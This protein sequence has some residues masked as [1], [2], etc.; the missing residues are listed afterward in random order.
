[1]ACPNP[2]EARRAGPAAAREGG[3]GLQLRGGRAEVMAAAAWGAVP[4]A[5]CPL[6]PGAWEET[7]PC[8]GP[9]APG[10]TAPSPASCSCPT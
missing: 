2:E 6:G 1:M 9:Q 5:G 8:T 7:F 3:P 4:P 10:T